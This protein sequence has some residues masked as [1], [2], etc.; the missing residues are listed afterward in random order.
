MRLLGRPVAVGAVDLAV[1]WRASMNR[2]VSA[3]GVA[4]FALSRNQSVHG[5][6][7]V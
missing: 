1:E 4:V 6:V 5:K 2:M 7:T 3:R